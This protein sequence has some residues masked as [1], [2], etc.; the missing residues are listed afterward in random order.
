INLE[1]RKAIPLHCN[2]I[3]RPHFG[4]EASWQ[5][6]HLNAQYFVGS[7]TNPSN[8]LG[9]NLVVY[10]Q[11]FWGIGP[12]LG[13]DGS[14]QCFEHLNLFANSGFATLLGPLKGT[15]QSYDTNYAAGYSGMLIA[16]Q[17]RNPTTLSPVMQLAIGVNTDWAYADCYHFS[18]NAAWEAQIWFFQ[19]QHSSSVAD[20]NLVM[21][22]LTLGAELTF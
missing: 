13:L 1:L 22:G 20:I 4:L 12:R 6:Q 3:L 5:T 18:L 15:S 19:N 17:L 8:N 2:F 16:D 14:W 10:N 21:Q 11:Y 9:N 7:I